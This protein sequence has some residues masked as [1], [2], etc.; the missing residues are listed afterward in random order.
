MDW[1]FLRVWYCSQNK[2]IFKHFDCLIEFFCKHHIIINQQIYL[3]FQ[4]FFFFSSQGSALGF[5]SELAVCVTVL[6]I[7]T[8][9]I[10]IKSLDQWLTW[11]HKISLKLTEINNTPLTKQKSMLTKYWAT[12]RIQ[13][14]W[15]TQTEI[16]YDTSWQSR[17]YITSNLIF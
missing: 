13:H 5:T 7:Q 9:R 10:K 14:F 15:L 4:V 1:Y 11:C 16:F 12:L 3:M 17:C 2:H 6:W 8:L